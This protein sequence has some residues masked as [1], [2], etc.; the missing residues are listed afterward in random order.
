MCGSSLVLDRTI[1]VNESPVMI[2]K[3]EGQ[4]RRNLSSKPGI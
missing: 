4:P 1:L 3:A 2:D